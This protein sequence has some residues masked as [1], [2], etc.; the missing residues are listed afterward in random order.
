MGGRGGFS[1]EMGKA[2]GLGGLLRE[3]GVVSYIGFMDLHTFGDDN[4][5]VGYDS[6]SPFINH[7]CVCDEPSKAWDQFSNFRFCSD[8]SLDLLGMSWWYPL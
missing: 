7:A 2:G 1:K 3:L 8:T 4:N 6:H 5:I